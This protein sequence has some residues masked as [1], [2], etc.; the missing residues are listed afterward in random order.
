[1]NEPIKGRISR[2]VLQEW[3][4]GDAALLQAVKSGRSESCYTFFKVP[5]QASQCPNQCPGREDHRQ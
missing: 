1:M 5:Q 4:N 2:E 3:L